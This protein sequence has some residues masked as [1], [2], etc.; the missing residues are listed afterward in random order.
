MSHPVPFASQPW[1]VASREACLDAEAL[2]AGR[3][4]WFSHEAHEVGSPPDWF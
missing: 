1:F 2:L 3:A 4:T